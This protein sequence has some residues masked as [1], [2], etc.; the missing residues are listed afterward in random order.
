MIPA[1]LSTPRN[2]APLGVIIMFLQNARRW[3]NLIII[4]LIPFFRGD[5]VLPFWVFWVFVA[6]VA[7]VIIGI[8]YWQWSNF[9]FHIHEGHLVIRQGVIRKEET[10]IPLERVQSVHIKQN[11]VQQLLKLASLHIDT[12]GSAQKEAQIPAL[13]L[14]FASSL[15]AQLIELRTK[16]E[17][18][19][20]VDDGATMA[21]IV[22]E[23]EHEL[24]KLS[25]L[26][27]IKVGLTENHVRS[28]LAILAI[29][30]G[31]T[32]QFSR[33]LG[34]DS[35]SVYASAA[36]TLAFVL[37]VTIVLFLIGSVFL[38]L[39]ITVM[40]YFNLK[41]IL[42]QSGLSV[43]AGLL[44]KQE[45]FVP[46]EKIQYIKWQSNPL[47]KLIGLKSLA[48]FQASSQ[49]ARKKTTVRIPGCKEDQINEVNQ[50]FYPE[51]GESTTTIRPHP[52][53][54]VRLSIIFIGLPLI[55]ALGLGYSGEPELASTILIYALIATFLIRSYVARFSASQ[56]RELL[57]INKGYIFPETTL[58]KLYKIQNVAITQSIFQKRRGLVSL[59]I[60]TAAGKLTIPFI[61]EAEGYLLANR[62]LYEVERSQLSWM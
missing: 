42:N 17:P 11:V 15:K 16:S 38:S 45:N 55:A 61:T 33:F 5:N 39:W 21:P 10:Q 62:F 24:M 23:E 20:I 44:K 56:G 30:F 31:Y 57:I 19:D 3:I 28:G 2:Q 1:D 47:R 25:P 60:Y 36:Q 46:V 27:L 48:I 40:R 49:G 12:A 41:V 6:V 54:Q 34:Y 14:D 9:L 29:I 35:D 18:V 22:N 58:L 4:G 37:P 32:E 13:K 51:L 7:I 50:A 43:K 8:S 26:D 59:K 53:W 52:F